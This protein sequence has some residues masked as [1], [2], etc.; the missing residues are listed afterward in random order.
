MSV[1]HTFCQLSGISLFVFITLL[2]ISETLFIYAGSGAGC[3]AFYLFAPERSF[4]L[5]LPYD[6]RSIVIAFVLLEQGR[7]RAVS[8]VFT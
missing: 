2:F 1:R 3:G 8:K 4:F 6:Y 7:Q 5:S